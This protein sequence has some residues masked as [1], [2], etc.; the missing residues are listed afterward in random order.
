MR[1]RCSVFLCFR[2]DSDT[3]LFIIV[4]VSK[5]NNDNTEHH[6]SH[7]RENVMNN[8]KYGYEIKPRPANL[9]GGW[10]L[11]MTHGDK[12]VGFGVYPVT[13]D[14]D[15][16]EAWN[17]AS[18]RAEEWLSSRPAHQ[19][20]GEEIESL[21]TLPALTRDEITALKLV[22]YQAYSAARRLHEIATTEHPSET[23][24]AYFAEDMQNAE[25]ISEA[26]GFSGY[27]SLRERFDRVRDEIAAEDAAAKLARRS[28][29]SN[30]N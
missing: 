27:G 1:V 26:L 15:E 28:K 17:D 20:T 5:H 10:N 29:Q 6:L 30:N 16:V 11:E 23:T 9:G 13:D 25:K 2:I 4:Y 12:I 19:D 3:E 22:I 7:L 24:A 18:E 14:C 8:Q 21:T